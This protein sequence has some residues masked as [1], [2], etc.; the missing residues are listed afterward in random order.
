MARRK[1]LK[2]LICALVILVW[3]SC[4]ERF[5]IRSEWFN[6]SLVV[7][8]HI[9]A[10]L[11][12]QQVRLSTTSY[13]NQQKF[14][15]ETGAEVF[16]NSGNGT[17]YQFSES[18]PGIYT[19]EPFAGI[20]GTTYQ[21]QIM[22]ANGRHYSSN[23]VEMRQTPVV[24]N[25]YGKYLADLSPDRRGVQIYVDTE[26]PTR[27]TKFFRWEYVETYIV[28][29][30]FPSF[31]EWLGGNEW[32]TRTQPVGLCYPTD[33]SSNVLIKST[34]GLNESKVSFPL[35]FFDNASYAL[36]IKYSILVR[37]YSLSEQGYR[38]WSILKAI[39]ESQGTVYDKQPGPVAGNIKAEGTDEVV[40]GYFD[41]CAVSSTR[42][43]IT[44]YQFEAAGYF[45]PHY[46]TS[47]KFLTPVI[48]PVDQ[49]G[50]FMAKNPGFLIWDATGGSFELLPKQCCDCTDLGTNIKPAFWQ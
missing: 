11:Q 21:L 29:T 18:A 28:Q 45:P 19:S 41:A 17:Q 10:D 46:Q 39:N 1:F 50:F 2:S 25:V 14:I 44:P 3:E 12:K 34:V 16:V 31:Y 32:V 23:E 20:P 9:T 4:V 43:F 22:R 35:R 36:K 33:S 38:Y 49:I 37:Q 7:D 26:D 15:P 47:C 5:D 27:E 30:P 8:G 42:V 6:E 13:I 24:G 48:A 40:L